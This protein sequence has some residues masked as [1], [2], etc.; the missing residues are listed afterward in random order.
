MTESLE[1]IYQVVGEQGITSLT[2]FF[3]SQ[4]PSD[5]ILGPMYAKED[6]IAAELRLRGF[7]TYR[8]GGPA[9][10]ITER[11]APR[12]RMRHAPF[13]IDQVARDRWVVLMNRALDQVA[14]P[15]AVKTSLRQFFAETATFLINSQN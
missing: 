8:L 11:G 9:S 1:T 7:L 14:F 6:L 12:L 13:V 4:I 15:D 2:G 10:Y 3:Y 5:E